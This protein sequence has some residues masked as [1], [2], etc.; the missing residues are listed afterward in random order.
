VKNVYSKAQIKFSHFLRPLSTALW[1]CGFFTDGS[2]GFC[3]AKQRAGLQI[4]K[5]AG[6]PVLSNRT[7]PYD[8]K[9][10]DLFGTAFIGK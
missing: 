8:S 5:G 3:D 4:P 6:K 9:A 10:G 7:S 1:L 2:A